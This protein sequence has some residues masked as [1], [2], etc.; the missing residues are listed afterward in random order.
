MAEFVDGRP[1]LVRAIN[2]RWLLQLWNRIRGE[3]ALPAWRDLDTNELESNTVNLSYFEVVRNGDGVRFLIRFHGTQMAEVY[4]AQCAGKF[5]DET[6]P[7]AQR[8]PALA[9]Y[10]YLLEVGRPIY[11]ISHIR[12][13]ERRVVQF[14]RLLLPF[15]SDGADV[16]RIL[17]SHELVSADGAFQM[18]NLMRSQT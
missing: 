15:A 1:D 11:T 5:L 8:I 9:V 2:Q 6:L 10:K 7:A 4:G 3:R 18:R 14:E 16:D 17:T 12:D 13:G